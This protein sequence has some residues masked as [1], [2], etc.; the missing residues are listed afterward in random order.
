MTSSMSKSW[1]TLFRSEASLVIWIQHGPGFELHVDSL[2]QQVSA[3]N[4]FL[5]KRK[6][7]DLQSDLLGWHW[8]RNKAIKLRKKSPSLDI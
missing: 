8:N 3:H 1:D 4:L 5:N 6:A 2:L 7:T